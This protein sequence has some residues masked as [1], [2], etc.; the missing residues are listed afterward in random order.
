[1]CADE[2]PVPTCI[3]FD[4]LRRDQLFSGTGVWE[5]HA[6]VG[7]QPRHFLSECLTMLVGLREVCRD[8][9][10]GCHDVFSRVLANLSTHPVKQTAGD[11]G[12]N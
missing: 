1:M 4:A 12:L 7:E 10:R 3:A 5:Q 8:E 6:F 2:N 9:V 11:V